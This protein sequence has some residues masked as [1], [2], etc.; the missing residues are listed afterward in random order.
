MGVKLMSEKRLCILDNCEY[1]PYLEK[2]THIET[3]AGGSRFKHRYYK[4]NK[5]LLCAEYGKIYL[6][7]PLGLLFKY[8]PLPNIEKELIK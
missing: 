4:C 7:N 1:C 8:C 6:K 2:I 5:T 3:L